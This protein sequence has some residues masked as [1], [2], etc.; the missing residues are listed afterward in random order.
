MNKKQLCIAILGPTA[1]GKTEFAMQV[2]EKLKGELF[3]LDSTTVYQGFDIGSAK[4]SKEDQIKIPHHLVDVLKP[5][6]PFSAFH[7]VTVADQIMTELHAKNTLPIIVGGTYFYLKAL[8]HGVYPTVYVPAETVDAIEKEFYD[9]DKLSTLKMHE[10]LKKKDPKSAARIHPNDKYRLLRA[11]A[12]IRTSNQK[13]SELEAT[14][15]SEQQKNRIW[16]KYAMA[17]NRTELHK[18]ILDRVEQMLSG[19]LIEEVQRLYEMHPQSRALGSIGYAE[20]LL[21]FQ[22]KITEKQLKTEIVDKTRQLAKRQ[23]TWLRSDPEL[24]F[25]DKSDVDRVCLDVT[26]LKDALDS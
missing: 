4:P 18:N 10:E 12:I 24:R 22:K 7:F 8:Q 21:Y 3:C 16:L 9:D 2:A 11:L 14:P 17:I 13:P 20:C 1:S 23:I 19:G 6:E 26:N 25:I 15:I 5:N